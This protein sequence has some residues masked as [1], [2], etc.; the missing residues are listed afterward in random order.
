MTT[1]TNTV[2]A[3]NIVETVN[4]AKLGNSIISAIINDARTFQRRYNETN[5]R[6][7]GSEGIVIDRY[8]SDG[9]R[10][11]TL[12]HEEL[13]RVHLG[14]SMIP[15]RNWGIWFT[16]MPDKAMEFIRQHKLASGYI[17]A[18]LILSNKTGYEF[19]EFKKL[20]KEVEEQINEGE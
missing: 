2:T 7:G 8:F 17:A 11:F 15:A 20:V 16:S 5:D 10:R 13:N 3:N 19:D 1:T 18:D 6:F 9:L 4:A 14:G 12:I